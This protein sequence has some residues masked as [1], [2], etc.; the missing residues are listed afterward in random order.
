M[1][2]YL[3]GET[4]LHFAIQQKE[5]GFVKMLLSYS[6]INLDLKNSSVGTALHLACSMDMPDV[7]GY[8]LK[9][10]ANPDIGNKMKKKPV[11]LCQSETTIGIM[12]NKCN[13]VFFENEKLFQ[14]KGN[15]RMKTNE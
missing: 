7:I 12:A 1:D 4:A 13:I 2:T 6:S 14:D 5:I 10:G 9:A 15:L 8:L 3:L 11:D